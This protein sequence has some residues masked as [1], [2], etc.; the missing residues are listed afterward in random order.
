[1]YSTISG[2]V[3]QVRTASAHEEILI[4]A[5]G[6]DGRNPKMGTV[7]SRQTMRESRRIM[8]TRFR[9][10]KKTSHAIAHLACA[11]R[12]PLSSWKQ[13]V[14]GLAM[15]LACLEGDAYT[16]SMTGRAGASGGSCKLQCVVDFPE[17]LSNMTCCAASDGG[18]RQSIVPDSETSKLS[19][20]VGPGTFH[21]R[22]A[23]SSWRWAEVLFGPI[24]LAGP[25]A[26]R[27][28][29]VLPSGICRDGE[30]MCSA[31]PSQ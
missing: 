16:V 7:Q 22:C 8:V 29:F 2:N 31:R 13:A 11:L 24:W 5:G 10:K 3:C 18:T 21:C 20:S 26:G 30:M 14:R 25:F 6:G 27:F 15:T 19:S 9:E 23:E 1:M 12:P 17:L 28:E 4:N